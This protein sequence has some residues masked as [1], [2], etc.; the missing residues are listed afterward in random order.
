[1]HRDKNLV[2]TMSLG[3]HYRN[4]VLEFGQNMG[5]PMIWV[6]GCQKMK[7]GN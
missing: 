7:V 2:E 3:V 4:S 5:M 6:I 1:M